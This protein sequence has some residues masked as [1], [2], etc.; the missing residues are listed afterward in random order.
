MVAPNKMAPSATTTP[1]SA[2]ASTAIAVPCVT[3]NQTVAVER[4]RRVRAQLA[5]SRP[6]R[7]DAAVRDRAQAAVGASMR[8]STAW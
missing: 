3:S 6:T 7:L 2:T 1:R 5:T 4:R 8:V